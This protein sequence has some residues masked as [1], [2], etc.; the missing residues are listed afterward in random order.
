MSQAA[1]LIRN[2]RRLF[3]MPGGKHDHMVRLLARA[4]PG[5]VGVIVAVMVIAPIFP[6][7]EVSFLLDRN[8]VAVT[9]ER[10]RM[11]QAT[12]RG[13]DNR[14][15]A[16]SLTAGNAVQRSA[17]VPVVEMKDLFAQMLMS[18]GPA[19]LKAPDGAFHYDTNRVNVRGPLD[20]SA[21]GGYRLTTSAVEIDLKQQHVTGS[22]GVSGAVPSGTFTADRIEADLD[23]RTVTLS[24]RARMR[25]QPGQLRVPA[26]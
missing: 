17:K 21:A 20:F 24:G 14:G 2:K 6:R 10:I 7:G 22:G 26:H 5:A 16:F 13:Q 25:M 9:Q 4:L 1:D 3:A 11:E 23:E 18:D 19:T 15:R 12:Y 8:K